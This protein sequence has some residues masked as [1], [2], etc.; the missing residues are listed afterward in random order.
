MATSYNS[1]IDDILATLKVSWDNNAG[2]LNGG[3]VPPFVDEFTERDL[4]PHPRNSA[5]AWMR[6]VVRHNDANKPTLANNTSVSRGRR[7]GK[8]SAEIYVPATFASAWTVCEELAQVVSL[9]Y[10]GNRSV[11]G[12]VVFTHVQLIDQPKDAAWVR[13][14]VAAFFYW[15]DVRQV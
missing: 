3:V 2:A 4:K 10:E 8:V 5:A 13:K 11:G 1:A 15:D 12:R 9:A 6:V 14:D 7:Y